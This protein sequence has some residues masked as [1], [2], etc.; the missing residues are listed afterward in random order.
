MPA[1]RTFPACLAA[2]M[3]GYTPLPA[4]AGR[5]DGRTGDARWAGGT[6]PKICAIA[7]ERRKT[8]LSL[9][10]SPRSA[11][12]NPIMLLIIVDYPPNYDHKTDECHRKT[13]IITDDFIDWSWYGHCYRQDQNYHFHGATFL[14]N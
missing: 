7:R 1:I 2:P 4:R 14:K 6:G 9:S 10:S 8:S 12:F 3:S 5:L 13:P 11:I